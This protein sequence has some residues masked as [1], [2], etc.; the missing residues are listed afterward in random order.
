MYRPPVVNLLLTIARGWSMTC[1]TNVVEGLNIA[2]D[3]N[4]SEY[5]GIRINISAGR[6]EFYSP[7]SWNVTDVNNVTDVHNINR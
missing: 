4:Q 5:A 6:P 2:C 3:W 1:C 7:C